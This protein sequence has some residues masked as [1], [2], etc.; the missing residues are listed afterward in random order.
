[1]ASMRLRSTV[2]PTA[3]AL[4]FLAPLASAAVLHVPADYATIQ[5]AISAATS[6]DEVLVAA[7]TY[8]EHLLIDSPQSG[9]KLHSES[10][11]AATIVDAGSLGSA[12]VIAAGGLG[13][14]VVGFT[15]QN[16]VGAGVGGG[17]RVINGSPLI[18]DNVIRQNKAQP[19]G[20]SSGRGG[21]IYLENSPATLLRNEIRDNQA[22]SYGGGICCGAGSAAMIQDNI[23]SGN[24]AGE[25]GGLVPTAG[26]VVT[27][28]HFLSNVAN[29]GGGGISMGGSQIVV[30]NNEF[31]NNS[32]VSGSGGAIRMESQTNPLDNNTFVGNVGASG[33]AIWAAYACTISNCVF[34]DNQATVGFGGAIACPS[35]TQVA[36]DH[37]V[38]ARNQAAGQGGGISIT[39]MPATL[40]NNTMV[41]NQAALGGGLYMTQA[42]VMISHNIISH[43][44]AGGGVAVG[45]AGTMTFWCDDVWGNTGGEYVGIAD[46]TGVNNC[47]KTDPLFCDLAALDLH[48]TAASPCTVKPPCLGIGAFDVGCTGPVP[49]QVTT[50]GRMKSLYR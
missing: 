4:L 3:F 2:P 33:G 49:V 39:S 6:G 10:G 46:Q 1:M 14:E 36:I 34:T 38:I 44:I 11:A 5:Q 48:L 29:Q 16:G 50:W 25:G 27:G 13:T 31:R 9:M 12:L 15:F 22:R 42:P 40:T 47:M 23:I 17:I 28:N 41:L 32:A 30:R 35:Y 8:H 7:G 21:G 45:T 24:V 43:S 19:D 20:Q 18:S 26:V 37:C